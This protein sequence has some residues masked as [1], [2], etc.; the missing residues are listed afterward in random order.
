MVRSV[1][2]VPKKSIGIDDIKDFSR[3]MADS[4]EVVTAPEN[5]LGRPGIDP[6]ISLHTLSL[7]MK[8]LPVVHITPRDKNA[9]H[10]T[11]QIISALK[12]GIESFLA[13]GGDRIDPRYRSGEVREMDVM[14]LLSFIK[15]AGSHIRATNGFRLDITT[16]AVINP[17]RENE[18]S[19][20]SA[21][22]E[23]GASFFVS[24]AIYDSSL[25]KKSWI[26]NRRFRLL[27]G[28][29]PI[30]R[31]S[32]VEFSEKLGIR[33]PENV[34][35]RLLS[36]EDPSSVSFRLIT[37]MIDDLKGYFDGVHIMPMGN[38]RL[39]RDILESI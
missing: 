33:L 32:T 10:I 13:I 37:Q 20:V 16:G 21:K 4:C 30:S 8:I 26:R 19:I 3:T 18:E 38:Y 14:G 35:Q 24:Q 17:Y 1:E 31:R 29:I 2:F 5:Q 25:L 15:S 39:A 7:D 34:R 11:S 22:T 12:Y 28:F 27:A 36:A 9:L 6:I 23:R